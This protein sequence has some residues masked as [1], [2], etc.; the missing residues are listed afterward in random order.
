MY[1]CL[2]YIYI[3]LRSPFT[4]EEAMFQNWTTKGQTEHKK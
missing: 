4:N 3:F 1:M 2:L